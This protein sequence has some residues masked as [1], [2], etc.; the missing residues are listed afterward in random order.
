MIS[1]HRMKSNWPC[2]DICFGISN[3]CG[4][5][6][7][8]SDVVGTKDEEHE[9]DCVEEKLQLSRS[10]FDEEMMRMYT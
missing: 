10:K 7:R 2:K 8:V 3:I 1:A 5:T 6:S 9:K 4:V